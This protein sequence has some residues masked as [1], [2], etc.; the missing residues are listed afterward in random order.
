MPIRRAQSR[1]RGRRCTTPA[2]AAS[3]L[4][5]AEPR[6]GLY[7]GREKLAH[8]IEKGQWEAK[9][10]DGAKGLVKDQDEL[11]G[12]IARYSTSNNRTAGQ[13]NVLR[14]GG[15]WLRLRQHDREGRGALARTRASLQLLHTIPGQSDRGCEGAV[16]T[17]APGRL[18][19]NRRARAHRLRQG[20]AQGRDRLRPRRSSRPWRTPPRPC[21]TFR[22]RT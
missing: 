7:T 18:R 21:T 11:D 9:A 16:P 10:Q 3:R 2:S 13:S 14:R 6:V 1:C 15:G 8:W 5:S 19:E 12:F 17:T 20:P 22:M 4:P